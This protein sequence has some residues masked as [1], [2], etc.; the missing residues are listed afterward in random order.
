M[1]ALLGTNTSPAEQVQA[2]LADLYGAT[3]M[4]LTDSGT[5]ALTLALRVT[6][7]SSGRTALPAYGCYD[8]ATAADGAGCEVL[9]YDLDPRTLGPEPESLQRAVRAG[10]RAIVVAPLFG[11]PIDMAMVDEIAAD[12]GAAIIEDAAQAAGAEFKGRRV[13]SF[14]S[15]SVLS[16]GRGK[17]TTGA[18]GGAL[19]AHDLRGSKSLERVSFDLRPGGP[20]VAG[21]ASLLAQWM[22]ARPSAYAFPAALPFLHLGETVYRCPTVPRRA[23]RLSLGTL[24]WTLELAPG[25]QEIRRITAVSYASVAE[26]SKGVVI[27]AIAA[28][29]RPGYLRFPVTCSDEKWPSVERAKRLGVMPGYPKGLVDLT[30]FS[31]RVLNREEE[32][33]GARH[34]ARRLATLPTHSRLSPG[35]RRELEQWLV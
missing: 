28:G 15:L 13:G 31:A 23:S 16:F 1:R 20:G 30:R 24:R 25:E 21:V 33:R 11:L 2:R 12:G 4:V 35:E 7:A 3:T 5:S 19:L 18:G 22:L 34:L 17:G 26:Q 14:G 10:A 29:G 27:P 9:L 6:V 8:I 32:F